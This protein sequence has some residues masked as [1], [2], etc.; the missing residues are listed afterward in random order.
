MP[1]FELTGDG[2]TERKPETFAQLAIRERE[3]LQRVLRDDIGV[4]GDDL[5]VISEEFGSWE[6]ARRRI[7]LLALDRQGRLVVIELKRT[8]SG[9][10]MELQALRYAAMVSAM[11]FDQRPASLIPAATSPTP[12]SPTTAAP[13]S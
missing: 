8:E 6:D 5:L 2:L 13:T 12:R 9:G 11:T 3:G 7:D 1:L 10:H 4:L